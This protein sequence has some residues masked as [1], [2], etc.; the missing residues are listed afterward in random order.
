MLDVVH[1]VAP[2]ATPIRLGDVSVYRL[3]PLNNMPYPV[4]A[5]TSSFC[6]ESQS[7]QNIQGPTGWGDGSILLQMTV[8]YDRS[9]SA[10]GFHVS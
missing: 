1:S 7:L 6:G 10:Q 3:I 5:W 9:S 2:S 4:T 8:Y